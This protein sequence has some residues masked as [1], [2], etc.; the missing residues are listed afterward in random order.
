MITRDGSDGSHKGL[1]SSQAGMESNAPAA[2]SRRLKHRLWV[3]TRKDEPP[4]KS[5]QNR[6]PPASEQPCLASK[7]AAAM[8]G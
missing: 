2:E 4:G 1:A 3:V 8:P 5:A 7:T 6:H